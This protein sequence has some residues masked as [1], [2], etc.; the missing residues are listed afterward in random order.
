MHPKA[1]K[2]T[3]CWRYGRR[4]CFV[5]FLALI[6]K[7][8]IRVRRDKDNGPNENS[9]SSMPRHASKSNWTRM[10]GSESS[11]QSCHC[12]HWLRFVSLLWLTL[13][14]EPERS[15]NM[16]HEHAICPHWG[17]QLAQSACHTTPAQEWHDM[18]YVQTDCRTQFAQNSCQTTTEIILLFFRNI[19]RWNTD[20]TP[21]VSIDQM[22]QPTA[23]T[24]WSSLGCRPGNKVFDDLDGCILLRAPAA[25][26]GNK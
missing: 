21:M 15:R 3:E 24:T 22:V 13:E 25:A 17:T 14:S 26:A 2:A 10:H 19:I 7:L 9:P 20:G 16:I 18:H 6:P 12:D 4:S 11:W 1:C 5:T 8:A 23:L